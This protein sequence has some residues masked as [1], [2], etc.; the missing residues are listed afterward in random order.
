MPKLNINNKSYLVDAEPDTPLLWV[1]RE[2]LRLTGTKFGSAVA[3]VG[4][5]RS[6]STAKPSEVV[7]F[8]LTMSM[9][10]ISQQLKA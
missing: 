8:E 9:A 3:I 5:V 2:D 7:N 6:M 4:P 1:L 10:H